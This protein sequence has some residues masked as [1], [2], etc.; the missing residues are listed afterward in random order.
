MILADLGAEVVRVGRIEH[1]GLD[2][3]DGDAPA[4]RLRYRKFDL[5]SR[6]RRSVAIDL[7][8]PDGLACAMRLV[9]QADVFIENLRPGATERLGLGPDVCLERNPR[10]V[11]ARMTGWGQE[12][13]YAS[14]PG[15]DLNFVALT[16]VLDPLRPRPGAAPHPPLNLLGDFAGGG[17]ILVIG[18]LSALL[19]RSFSGRGQVVDASMLDGAALLTTLFHGLRAEGLWSDV[20]GTNLLDLGSPF[21]NVYETADGRYIA[22][23]SHEPQHRVRLLRALELAEDDELWQDGD[24]PARWAPAKRRLAAIFATRPMKKWSDLL[25]R[26]GVC[27]TP[28]LTLDEAPRHPHNVARQTFV[29]V[30]G[31]VQPAP[32][33]RFQ[34][35]PAPPPGPPEPTGAHTTAALLDWSFSEAEVMELRRAG[36]VRQGAPAAQRPRARRR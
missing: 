30:D 20:P 26:A 23:A 18:I 7:K 1:V 2:I 34:R 5:L 32:A 3:G 35:T 11:Y 13:P 33:P 10:L 29:E 15:H 22:L 27:C 9:A 25:E 4:E 8:H 31:V 6:G 16:G 21:Y 14:S 24:D 12:G 19:E 36:A 17:T 28:V